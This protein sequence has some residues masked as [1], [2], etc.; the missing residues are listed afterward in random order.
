MAVLLIV[1]GLVVALAVAAF[2]LNGR[3]EVAPVA[4]RVFNDFDEGPIR[5]PL[6]IQAIEPLP[7]A[8][9]PQI[10]WT[11]QFEPRS[12]RLSDEARLQLIND[13]GLL[14]APWCLPLLTQ[15]YEEEP[16]LTHRAAAQLALA[17]FREKNAV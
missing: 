10:H 16:D 5:E 11:K 17:R 6:S 2:I 12:G 4:A 14:R 15:A 8:E 9:E 1:I 7:V 3:R 13:L